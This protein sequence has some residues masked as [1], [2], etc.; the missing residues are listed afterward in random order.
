MWESLIFVGCKIIDGL[1]RALRGNQDIRLFAH[2]TSRIDLV[3][4]LIR[5]L[6]YISGVCEN[7]IRIT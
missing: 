2:I 3:S 7:L 5:E 4:E 1:T 6:H